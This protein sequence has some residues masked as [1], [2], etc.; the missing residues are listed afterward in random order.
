MRGLHLP[1]LRDDPTARGILRDVYGQDASPI[2][3][4]DEEAVERPNVIVG[5]VKKSMAAIASRWFRRKASQRWPVRISGRFF[6]SNGRWF[7]RKDQNRPC[8]VPH[9]SWIRG[10]PQVGFSTT[11]R[12][13]NSRTSFG[14]GLL[15]TCLR[16][17]E[18][19]R[20]YIRKAIQRQRTGEMAPGYVIDF[21]VGWSFGERQELRCDLLI[22]PTSFKLSLSYC[23]S[24]AFLERLG[25]S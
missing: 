4:N 24:V 2:V 8:G 5:T 14:V 9:G 21:A 10:A 12:K 3:A 6:S 1:N 13:I 20:Q 7:S 22:P 16:T 19:S 15:P 25:Q 11:I 23:R 18:V 17:L